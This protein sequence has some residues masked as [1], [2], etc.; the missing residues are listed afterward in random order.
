MKKLWQSFC[1]AWGMFCV[2]PAPHEPWDESAR[3]WMIVWLPVI[4]LALGAC[5]FFLALLSEG[6]MLAAWMTVLPFLFTG[7]LHL[8]GYMDCCDA[9]L[10]R[11]DLQ[12]RQKIL[13]DSHVGAF[14]V[15]GAAVLFLL[16][17]AAFCDL[18]LLAARG[19]L[20]L[21]PVVSRSVCALAVTT[22]APMGT[23]QYAGAFFDEKKLPQ[24][25]ILAAELVLSLTAGFV[26][27]GKG[28]IC[29]AVTGV[30]AAIFALLG[31]KQLGGMS[32]DISGF[33]LTLGELCGILSASYLF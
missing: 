26:F 10:S 13:K 33:A 20:L 25:L 9:I 19:V 8:D 31:K 32:G 11:R 12:T 23:S 22:L 21:L 15:I 2:I 5:W 17:F 29:L 4:G 27:F 6:V 28:V 16:Q 14:A 7:F 1:M 24:L 30:C 18:A 3:S